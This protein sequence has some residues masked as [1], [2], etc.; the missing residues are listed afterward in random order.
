[1]VESLYGW[2]LDNTHKKD[3]PKVWH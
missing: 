1:M 2:T 3:W